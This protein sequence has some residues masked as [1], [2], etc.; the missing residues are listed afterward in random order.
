MESGHG[1][2][3]GRTYGVAAYRTA[4]S[5]PLCPALRQLPCADRGGAMSRASDA[6]RQSSHASRP[7][8]LPRRPGARAGV[9][10]HTSSPAPAP[11]R[12]VRGRDGEAAGE[13]NHP[14][15][16]LGETQISEPNRRQPAER[17]RPDISNPKEISGRMEIPGRRKSRAGRKSL[18]GGNLGPEGHNNPA[19]KAQPLLRAPAPLAA[20]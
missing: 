16:F 7:S 6:H 8:Q 17:F 19:P 20:P 9:C 13:A 18:A 15:G 3:M 5:P 10:A 1:A 4:D 2:D 11:R 12:C 14:A